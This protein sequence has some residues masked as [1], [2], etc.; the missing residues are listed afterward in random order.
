MARSAVGNLTAS[1]GVRDPAS[2]IY[3]QVDTLAA[4]LTL[5]SKVWLA[6]H[7]RICLTPDPDT[8][9]SISAMAGFGLRRTMPRLIE[10]KLGIN[11]KFS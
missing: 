1:I 2:V 10:R 4:E 8:P 5:A 3:N 7:P 9:I 11:L 6:A